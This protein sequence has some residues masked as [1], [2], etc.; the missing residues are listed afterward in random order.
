[1]L[2]LLR[3]PKVVYDYFQRQWRN[4]LT[5]CGKALVWCIALSGIGTVSVQMPLYQAFCALVMLLAVASGACSLLRPKVTMDVLLPERAT[6][7]SP[8]VGR[9]TLTNRRRVPAFD[10]CVGFYDLPNEFAPTAET[11]AVPYLPGKGTAEASFTLRPRW[12]GRY[13]LPP[14]RAWSTFPFHIGRG[15]GRTGQAI[16]SLLVRPRF[17]PLDRLPLP[18]GGGRGGNGGESGQREGHSAEYLGNRDLV[19][20]ELGVRL[21]ARAWARTGRPVVRQYREERPAGVAVVFDPRCSP[22]A[23]PER[24]EAAVSRAAAVCEAVGRNGGDLVLFA[25]GAE[26]CRFRGGTGRAALETALD[27]LAVVEPADPRSD[28]FAGPALWAGLDEVAAVALIASDDAAP[29][30]LA[31]RLGAG[32]RTVISTPGGPA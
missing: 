8:V 23:P 21:D 10:V 18:A 4:E 27:A 17:H 22:D 3:L 14:L 15:G 24:F 32:G 11:V 16:G 9:A 28:P 6:A 30:A 31:A 29:G 2:A 7:G 20:G 1:M 13:E 12:R 26:V 19:P 5:V 25:A